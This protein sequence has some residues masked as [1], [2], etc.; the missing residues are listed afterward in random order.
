MGVLDIPAVGVVALRCGSYSVV[1]QQV[2]V[3]EGEH[4]RWWFRERGW[5]YSD[6]WGALVLTTCG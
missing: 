5:L 1:L 2:Q 6:M 4:A 3:G